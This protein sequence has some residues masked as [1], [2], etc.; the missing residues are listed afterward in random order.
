MIHIIAFCF[1]VLFFVSII[2]PQN[3]T[4]ARELCLWQDTWS[5][6]VTVLV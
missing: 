3:W 4:H 1:F 5:K 2:S 6:V